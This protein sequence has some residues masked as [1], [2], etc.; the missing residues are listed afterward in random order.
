M[1]RLF[2]FLICMYAIQ[3]SSFDV[4]RLTKILFA[5]CLFLHLSF[6]SVLVYGRLVGITKHTLRTDILNLL[7]GCNLTLPDVKVDYNRDY[8]PVGM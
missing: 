8:L 7:E 1:Y 6:E 5:L 3:H 2:A 4:Y